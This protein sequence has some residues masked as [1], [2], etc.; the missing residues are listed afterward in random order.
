M[1]R[2]GLRAVVS[3]V[4]V[5]VAGSRWWVIEATG[6]VSG[7]GVMG[8]LVVDPGGTRIIVRLIRR[9]LS[10]VTVLRYRWFRK[11]LLTQ[12]VAF[13][14]WDLLWRG[15]PAGVLRCARR[16]RDRIGDHRVACGPI[17]APPHRV[18]MQ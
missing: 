15:R 5:V 2:Q 3:L 8:L 1:G 12:G 17:S 10:H 11:L 18:I 16:A 14:G 9:G 7:W 4:L 6:E 13:R